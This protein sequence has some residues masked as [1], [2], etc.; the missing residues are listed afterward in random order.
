MSILSLAQKYKCDRPDFPNFTAS[1]LAGD[2][3][4]HQVTVPEGEELTQACV[5]AKFTMKA[6]QW[7]FTQLNKFGN[8]NEPWPNRYKTQ[9]SGQCD[10]WGQC[11]V[12]WSNGE[13][14][15][16]AM[17]PRVLA[18]HHEYYFISYWC[19]ANSGFPRVWVYSRT[20]EML[21]ST[22]DTVNYYLSTLLPTL[23][24][25]S[26]KTVQQESEYTNFKCKYNIGADYVDMN[27][28]QEKEEE[29][30]RE[31]EFDL[32]NGWELEVELEH[33]LALP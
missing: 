17:A 5:T 25:S 27:D 6:N 8:L 13:G 4:L 1:Y 23:N 11:P 12:F 21:G 14:K 3:Y 15:L 20:P 10:E 7:G 19:D 16:T 28:K 29:N 22:Q 18:A 33:E 31:V 26:L 9:I 32:G 2:W 30:E 24:K